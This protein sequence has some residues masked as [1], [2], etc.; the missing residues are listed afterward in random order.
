MI[1]K[2]LVKK[3]YY[4][5]REF[6]HN[7][8]IMG[9]LNSKL[10]SF[11]KGNY[12]TISKL[13]NKSPNTIYIST[14]IPSMWVGDTLISYMD[15]YVKNEKYNDSYNF[16]LTHIGESEEVIAAAFND[17]NSRIISINKT[18]DEQNKVVS[19][20]V[21]TVELQPNTE[22]NITIAGT[23]LTMTLKAPSAETIS[24]QYIGSFDTG[25]T[26]PTITWP[27]NVIWNNQLTLSPKS[28]YEFSIKYTN[29]KYYG[30]LNT[31][32]NQ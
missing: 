19:T 29:G 30:L 4:Y 9:N 8:Y 20:S 1:I 28:H 32:S 31:W 26:V 18:I 7:I 13:T 2:D 16:L 15:D 27:T 21:Q 12:D 5:I 10:L 22:Y 14:D 11:A 6:L 24:T 17:L 23:A 25:D 3:F